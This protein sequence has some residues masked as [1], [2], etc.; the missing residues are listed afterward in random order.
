MVYNKNVNIKFVAHG[1]FFGIIFSRYAQ[2]QMI[3]NQLFEKYLGAGKPQG[4]NMKG[5][6]G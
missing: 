3:G 2:S 4:L 1:A 5:K 6:I